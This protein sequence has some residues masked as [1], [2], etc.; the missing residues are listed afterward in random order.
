[1]VPA[2][3]RDWSE[4]AQQNP[5]SSGSSSLSYN[6]LLSI[7]NFSPG[8]PRPP[9]YLEGRLKATSKTRQTETRSP[10]KVSRK[11]SEKKN[12]FLDLA[13]GDLER[14]RRSVDL[15]RRTLDECYACDVE[16]QTKKK[17][18]SQCRIC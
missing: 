2:K 7:I 1:M 17:K 8:T 3:T 18:K 15:Y 14:R 16:T 12:P 13:G 10:P 4:G 9:D 6:I 5:P 11:K